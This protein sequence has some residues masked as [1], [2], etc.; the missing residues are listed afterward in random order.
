[1]RESTRKAGR[2]EPLAASASDAARG[3][4]V[5]PTLLEGKAASSPNFA[6]F[7][8]K[9]LNRLE[10]CSHVSCCLSVDEDAPLDSNDVCERYFYVFPRNQHQRKTRSV[11]DAASVVMRRRQIPA[12]SITCRAQ[13]QTSA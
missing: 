13:G 7:F 5:R 4:M 9:S 3:C 11:S 8:R 10:T 12:K 2:G 6:R 1:M